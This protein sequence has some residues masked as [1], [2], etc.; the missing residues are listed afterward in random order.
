MCN[1]LLNPR[2]L[3]AFRLVMQRGSVTGAAAELRISQPAV[4]RFIRDL[5][6]RSGITL[7]ERTGNHLIPTPE[8]HLLLV[9]VERYA[10]GIDRKSVV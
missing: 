3:E 8:A 5:E 10:F 1:V 7:F 9:E 6:V 2:Q 4:S